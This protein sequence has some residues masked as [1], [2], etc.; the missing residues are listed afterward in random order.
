MKQENIRIKIPKE[1]NSFKPQI[2]LGLTGRQLLCGGV[3]LILTVVL[4]NTVGKYVSSDDLKLLVSAIP[5]AIGGAFGWLEPY[6]M[7]FEQF[8]FAYIKNNILSPSVRKYKAEN[9]FET[10][11]KEA[12]QFVEL[13]ENKGKK[14]KKKKKKYKMSKDAFL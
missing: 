13:E 11:Q 4:Y 5:L 8:I 9:A 10:L 2:A 12:E 1:I 3:G 6:G 7:K 14:K